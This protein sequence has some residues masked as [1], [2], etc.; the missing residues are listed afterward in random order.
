M[1]SFL[2]KE[3]DGRLDAIKRIADVSTF[4]VFRP[5]KT[6]YGDQTYI[7]SS[8]VAPLYIGDIFHGTINLDSISSDAFSEEDEKIMSFIKANVEI[9]LANY[10]MNLD[11]LRLARYDSLSGLYNRQYFQELYNLSKE[12]ALR[13]NE[14]MYLAIFDIDKFKYVNDTF[15]HLA[16]DA[17]LQYFAKK[18]SGLVRK[19]DLVGRYGG[20]EFLCLFYNADTEALAKR[21]ETFAGD[22]KNN[23]VT[24]SGTQFVCT[25]CVGI[26]SFGEDGTEFSDLFNAADIR[27]YKAKS[28]RRAAS[29]G[30]S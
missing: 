23:P 11:N 9:A 25:F 29:N 20:D 15:G 18:L 4:A 8:I 13:Y 12:K 21:L 2:Y 30:K 10:R 22:L 27:M 17:V 16:G 14:K 6:E 3:T 5:I 28:D 24:I 7:K 19:S 26:S 1:E